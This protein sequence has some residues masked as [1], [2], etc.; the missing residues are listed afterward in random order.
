MLADVILAAAELQVA[1]ERAGLDPEDVFWV[2]ARFAPALEARRAGY[3]EGRHAPPQ[4]ALRDLRKD[5]DLALSLFGR[6][7]APTPLTHASR[8]LVTAASNVTPDLDI[9]AVVLPYRQADPR[10]SSRD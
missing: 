4:F 8:E 6:T 3:L 1:G 5:L 9:S 10:V 7:N 2:L